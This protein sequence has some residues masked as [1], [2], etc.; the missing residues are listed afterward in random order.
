MKIALLMNQHAYAGR[1]YLMNLNAADIFVDVLCFGD[2]P[3]IDESED[4]RCNNLWHPKEIESLVGRLDFYSFKSLSDPQF[5][6]HLTDKKYDLGIQGGTG[7]LKD[8]VFDIFKNGILNFHPGD[9]PQ[10]RGCSAPEWQVLETNAVISTC[11]LISSAID[12]GDI[13][14]KKTLLLNYNNYHAMRASIYPET[15]KFVAETIS[16]IV[17][18]NGFLYELVKQDEESAQ[19]RRPVQ[20]NYI[21]KI[22]DILTSKRI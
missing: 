17:N 16:E 19:Y 12:S 14:K 13:Y 18:N 22:N 2:N 3:R 21:A 20:A 8:N 11:H 9:L 4:I 15:G 10:Y 6:K 1:E 5:I 7:I